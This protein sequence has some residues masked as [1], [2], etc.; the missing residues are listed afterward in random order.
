M[1]EQLE[2]LRATL[3]GQYAIEHL[4]GEGGMAMVYL[5]HD[6][7]HDRK[8]AIKIMRDEVAAS[9][10]SSRFLREIQLAAQLQHPH[11]L[12]LIDSG[13][14]NGVLYYVMPYVEGE[15]LAA[16]LERERQLP[17]DDAVSIALEVAGALSHAHQ[18]GIIHRDVKP[19][20]ILLSGGHA[21][22]MDFGIGRA[23]SAAGGN[24]L[25]ETGFAVGTP[26]YMSP[27]QASGN[28]DLDGRTDVYALGCVLYEMLSG[29]P[30]YTGPTPQAI[31]AKTLTDPVPSVKRL[32][33]TISPVVD[34]ALRKSLAKVPADRF[35]TAQAF[36]DA[37]AADAPAISTDL[38][39][40][41]TGERRSFPP[42][43]VR[44]ARVLAYAG[45]AA[46]V[47]L[48]LW[49]L[50]GS[51]DNPALED[52]PGTTI[53]RVTGFAGWEPGP[54]W[55]P[56][57][58]QIAFSQT[59]DGDADVVTLALG[60]A[61]PHVL[62]GDSPYDE[63]NPRWSPDGSKL[64]FV[65]DRGKG[66]NVYWIP[67]TGGTERFIAETGLPFLERMTS[68]F[69]ILGTNPW[70]QDSKSLL[71][72]RGNN[73]GGASLWKV[74]L[75]TGE[76]T[77]LTT[78]PHG[79]E[80]NWASWS[81]DGTRIVFQRWEKG[82]PTVWTL[83]AE[84]GEP[85]VVL[86]DGWDWFP[87]WFPDGK[88]LIFT[89]LRGGAPNIWE[90]DVATGRAHQRTVGG[91]GWHWTP[92]VGPDGSILYD[93]FAHQV[94]IHWIPLD[95]PGDDERVT[96]LTGDNFGP[97]VSPND[98][99]ILW[100]RG[101]LFD[102]WIFD[103]TA[104]RSYQLTSDP[105]NDRMGDW[106]PTGDEIVFLS[107]RGGAVRLWI[108][109]VANGVTRQLSDHELS[110][111]THMADTQSGPRWA[112]DGSAI[113]Y[114]GQHDD[115]G[116]A[117]WLIDPDGGNRRELPIRDPFSFGW[118]RDGQRL[119]YLRR[120]ADGSGADELRATHL[121]TGQDVL[122]DTGSFS[123]VAV[124]ADGSALTY[125]RSVSHF[126]MELILQRLTPTSESTQLP[127]LDGEP[128]QLTFGNGEWHVHGGGFSWDGR[129]VTYTRDRDYGDLF[130]IVPSH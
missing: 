89:S 21:V 67:P 106:S 37:I 13:E 1:S 126:T 30:P 5:A 40:V 98:S 7:K 101:P 82:V 63:I 28:V 16:R 118:Y 116:N 6:L 96:F 124:S 120:A 8:V 69:F 110:W 78:P 127:A 54:S 2:R 73:T 121:A 47:S 70:S 29:E 50:W 10:G 64:A 56:D 26:A 81:P 92:V 39:R 4:L 3:A 111:S 104:N 95:A 53:T 94:D 35:P 71:F 112:P 128:Q 19:D 11:I 20:N 91:A 108:V 65:S 117:I 18:R 14:A 103:R 44:S 41:A 72:S 22:V 86:G 27:E 102:L 83:P 129:G 68:W 55:S 9:L 107:D 74:D 87:S 15:T 33:E 48:L 49:T 62:T 113:A 84:G 88:R 32:R 23:V 43:R 109:N 99:L 125:I 51:R 46:A 85:T 93:E 119:I 115:S 38:Q 31:L 42:F 77:Q 66:S 122:L 34:A 61:E 100:T 25:T 60:G 59:R 52:M 114:L 36:A 12:M 24:R 97:R 58:T 76:K 90:A 130:R 17:I 80:D 57:G 75:S 45:G 79:A 105:A 123:E